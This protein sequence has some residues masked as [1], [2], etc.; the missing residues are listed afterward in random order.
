MAVFTSQQPYRMN[1]RRRYEGHKVSNNCRLEGAEGVGG[2]TVPVD[3]G[4]YTAHTCTKL[5]KGCRRNQEWQ[6]KDGLYLQS[7]QCFF[8]STLISKHGTVCHQREATGVKYVGWSKR[9]VPLSHFPPINWISIFQITC[10]HS[11][12]PQLCNQVDRNP[13][14]MLTFHYANGDISLVGRLM[15]YD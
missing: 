2:C 13:V 9:G 5:W 11:P 10:S 7:G 4:T 1:K 14:I 3:T 8:C 6:V 15:L 12:P